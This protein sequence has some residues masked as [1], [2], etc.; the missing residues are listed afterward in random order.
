MPGAIGWFVLLALWLGQSA[1][2]SRAPRHALTCIAFVLLT[3]L[4]AAWVSFVAGYYGQGDLLPGRAQNLPFFLSVLGLSLA[5]I[6]AAATPYRDRAI[7]WLRSHLPRNAT[8]ARLGLAAVVLLVLSPAAVTAM[9]QLWQAPDFRRQSR[10]QF[11]ALANDPQPIAYVE[12]IATTPSLLFANALKDDAKTWP[13]TCLAKFFAKQAVLPKP[14]N[15]QS[16]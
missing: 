16:R 11:D 3:P 12:Q 5:L 6:A 1:P 2:A 10:A 4:G 15:G 8:R 9:W 14:S 7:A 13:N